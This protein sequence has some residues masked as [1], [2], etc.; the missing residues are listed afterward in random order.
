MGVYG[1]LLLPVAA[2]FGGATTG[3]PAYASC[4]M[5]LAP[6][7]RAESAL[8]LREEGFTRV[9]VV[10]REPIECDRHGHGHGH[11]DEDD[12]D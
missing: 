6:A 3:I 7:A 4:G 12:D 9:E 1:V 11:G 2:L 8:R 10:H 5:L